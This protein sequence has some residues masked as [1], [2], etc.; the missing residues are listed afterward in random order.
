MTDLATVE[1]AISER[2]VP[3]ETAVA[4]MERRVE[5]IAAGE[6]PELIWLLEHPPLYTA[7]TSARPADLL[8]PDRFP[9]HR[10][11]RGGQYTY[12]GPGQRIAYVLLDMRER[13]RDVR[14][15]VTLL[16]NWIIAAL[17]RCNVRGEVRPDRI[18]IWVARPERRHG[19][20]DKIAAIG[21]RLRHW[22]SFHGFS[23][24]VDPNLEH[25]SGIVPCGV[26]DHG[27]TSLVDLGLLV[28]MADVDMALEAAFRS[29]GFETVRA[30]APA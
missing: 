7:G 11:G 4:C 18:G 6:A 28:S 9:V 17:G 8:S 30:E 21:L 26:S 25:F 22:I 3:Y 1:W 5:L 23:L 27:V 24:N 14:A 19:A 12:H 15:L 10:T 13:G 29:K 16:E 20:E 2:Q